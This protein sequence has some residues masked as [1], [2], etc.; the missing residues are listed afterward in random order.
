MK[1]GAKFISLVSGEFFLSEGRPNGGDVVVFRTLWTGFLIFITIILLRVAMTDGCSC[2]TITFWKILQ[3]SIKGV[4]VPTIFGATYAAFYA[5]FVS[6]WT[7]IA[8]LYNQIKQAE[9]AAAGTALGRKKQKLVLAQWK[10]AFIEDALTVHMATK[11][12]MKGVVQ[13]WYQDEL[14]RRQFHQHTPDALAKVAQLQM[15][16]VLPQGLPI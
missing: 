16:G 2:F 5:R 8:N 9:V 14:V 7:Y 15:F 12:P 10:A 1:I 3:E 13:A 4:E 6:Q 11:Q